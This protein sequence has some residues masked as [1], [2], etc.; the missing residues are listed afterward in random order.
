MRFIPYASAVCLSLASLTLN[1]ADYSNSIGMKFIEIPA[2][3]FEIGGCNKVFYEDCGNEAGYMVTID[4]AFYL[5]QTEVTQAQWEAVMSSNPAHFKGSKRP[6]EEVRWDDAQAF[7]RRLNQK[8]GGNKYRLPTEA[9]WEYAARAG[10][11]TAYSFGD[12][13]SQLGQYAWYSENAG[14]ETHSVAQKKPNPWGL[15]DMHGNVWEWTCSAWSSTYNGEEQQCN[16]RAEF[17]SLRGGSWNAGAS[18]L[19]SAYRNDITPVNRSYS[20]G[21]RLA[22]IK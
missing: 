2:G 15:Y 6:V 4:K 20:L 14:S 13:V 9:E 22:R 1:A 16:N 18:N 21:L 12:E 19:R 8:E 10:T 7:I 17:R 5:S 11:R 3:Q